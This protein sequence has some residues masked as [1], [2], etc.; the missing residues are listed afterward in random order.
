VN[1]AGRSSLVAACTLS[2]LAVSVQ[3]L[4]GQQVAGVAAPADR[5]AATAQQSEDELERLGRNAIGLGPRE[6]GRPWGAQVELIGSS[7]GPNRAVRTRLKKDWVEFR[8]SVPVPGGIDLQ[9]P[10]ATRKISDLLDQRYAHA[11]LRRPII[12]MGAT[13][14]AMA[15]CNAE[16]KVEAKTLRPPFFNN[17]T[18][19]RWLP[20]RGKLAFEATAILDAT[21]NRCVRGIVDLNDGEVVCT[22]IA[23]VV[24]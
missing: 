21:Q 14:T 18:G 17:D 20:D 10:S 24:R 11:S 23:C 6:R 13:R 15:S 4:F 5:R 7:A 12:S 19:I 9:D 3:A 16:L 8:D 22:P 2:I 1:H